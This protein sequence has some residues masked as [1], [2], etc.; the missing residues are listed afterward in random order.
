[1]VTSAGTF[2]EITS[3]LSKKASI[4]LLRPNAIP[5]AQPNNIAIEKLTNNRSKVTPK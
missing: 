3:Q 2:K 4:F 5:I 1:M